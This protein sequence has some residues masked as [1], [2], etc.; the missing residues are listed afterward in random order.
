MKGKWSAVQHIQHI[1]KGIGAFCKYLALD[2]NIIVNRFGITTRNSRTPEE[3]FLAYRKRLAEGAVSTP[4]FNPQESEGIS[5]ETERKTGERILQEMIA[6][7]QDWSDDELDRY[8]CPHP[9][10]GKMTTREML[11][12]T[13]LHADHH[14]NSIKN[15][16]A[17]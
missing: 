4:P 9:N 6:S 2:K 12:F 11:Y 1:T 15:I 13:I 8:V 10:L 7:L 5:L 17:L 14:T 3:I 16:K